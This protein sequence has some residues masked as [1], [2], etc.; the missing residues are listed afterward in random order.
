MLLLSYPLLEEKNKDV[1]FTVLL[2]G[3]NEVKY[4]KHL[5]YREEL[6]NVSCH[7]LPTTTVGDPSSFP[8][9]SIMP[10]S[11]QPGYRDP[12]CM[13]MWGYLYKYICISYT[14]VCIIYGERERFRYRE[15]LQNHNTIIKTKKLTFVQYS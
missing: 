3:L 2:C 9:D 13:G 11:Y 5:A 10:T 15:E 6:Q 4:Y 1:Y 7:Q 14:H 8:L 12:V